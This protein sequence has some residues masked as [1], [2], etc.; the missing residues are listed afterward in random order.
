MAS[1]VLGIGLSHSPMMALPGEKW[2][3]YAKADY[4]H[5]MLF[6]ENGN[7]INYEELESH[8]NARYIHESKS[9]NL[10]KQWHQMRESFTRLREDLENSSPDVLIVIGNEHIGEELVDSRY[11]PALSMY[12]GNTI[13]SGLLHEFK[14][15]E[16][17]KE[18]FTQIGKGLGM[19]KH[20]IWPGAGEIAT[21]LVTS[22]IELEF[23]IGVIKQKKNTTHGHA[24]TTVVIEL[25]PEKVIP[26]IPLHLNTA[27]PNELT[28]SR[29]YDLGR[30]LR[31]AIEE[32]PADL[33][34]GIIASGGLSHFVTDTDIDTR[35]IEALQTN[36]E[37]TLRQLP[38]E[39]LKAGSSEIRN[40]VLLAGAMESMNLNWLD[41]NPVF[42]TP[43]GT[44]I[45]MTFASWS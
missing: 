19:D 43:G 20:Y 33:R 27:P 1:L 41:Y 44:G 6:D 10:I 3:Y 25:M 35:V 12:T 37:K 23:D 28:P 17:D 5:P 22:L 13:V 2:E 36:S 9:D 45:G 18:V 40:W 30:A 26:M 31:K 16:F 7:R 14:G 15:I 42:R 24:W 32:L 29:C 34:V 8:R 39:R 11:V 21:K 38:R 4:G